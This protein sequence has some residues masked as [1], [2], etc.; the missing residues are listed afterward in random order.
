M[1]GLSEIRLGGRPLALLAVLSGAATVLIISGGSGRSPAQLAALVALRQRP[2]VSRRTAHRPRRRRLRDRPA[3]RRAAPSSTGW[4]G[5]GRRRN[6]RPGP[7]AATPSTD[8]TADGGAMRRARLRRRSASA[9]RRR[10]STCRRSATCSRSRCPPTATR[11][12][13][14]SVRRPRIFRLPGVEGHAAQRLSVA[15]LSEL[16]DYLAMVSGQ[17][18]ERGH[19]RRLHHVRRFSPERRSQPDGI[20]RGNGCVYPET[21][22]TIGD[23]VTASGHLPGRPTS[24][25]WARRPARTRTRTP[26]NG[27]ALPG[28]QPG[29][30]TRPT[31]SSI[32]IRCSISAT[33]PPTTR[34]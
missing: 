26:R 13:S 5:P 31:R 29:C 10:V 6:R 17:A 23:Q 3:G 8:T 21:A 19:Q 34:T 22:L 25:T 32:S 15:R 30:D 33:A 1:R 18:P 28:T 20:V 14:A 16:A 12:P 7:P 4:F 2:G 11:T 27:V 24:P 9:A